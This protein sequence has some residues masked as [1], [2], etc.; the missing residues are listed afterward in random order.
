MLGAYETGEEAAFTILEKFGYYSKK[1][2]DLDSYASDQYYCICKQKWDGKS[3]MIEC[4][5]C[6]EWFHFDC[7]DIASAPKYW[8][9]V[10]CKKID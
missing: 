2:Q 1:K 3:S 5:F 10:S 6:G 9:C 4:D 8:A 7:V